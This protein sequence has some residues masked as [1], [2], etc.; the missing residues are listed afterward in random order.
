[1]SYV[2]RRG[3]R[4]T[5]VASKSS[6]SHIINDK[7]VDEYL[8]QCQFPK[9]ED[10]VDQLDQKLIDFTPL[11]SSQIKNVIAFDGGYSDVIVRKEFPSSKISF[12]QFGALVFTI[13]DLERL[14]N[15]PF[16]APEDM[17]K[18]K[19][20]ERQKLVV[21]VKN[22]SFSSEKTLTHSIRR[23]INDF[24]CDENVGLSEALKWIIFEEYNDPIES[25]TLAS[26]PHCEGTKISLRR[27][28]MKNDFTFSCS[29][30]TGTL[31]LIDVL[32]LH[33]AI[34]DELGAGGILGY[35]SSAL[36]QILVVYILK[37]LLRIAPD[38]ICETL[39]IKNGPLAFFGQTAN[40][41]KP[42]RKLCAWLEDKHDLALVGLEKSGPFVEHADE[43]S[44]KMKNGQVLLLDNEYIYKYITPGKADP[45]KPYGS[46]SYYSSK[47]IYKTDYG[48]MYVISLPTKSCLLQVSKGDFHRFDEVLTNV[49]K[50][51]C[52]MYDSSLIPVALANKL[53]SLSNHPSTQI[54]HKFAV[55]KVGR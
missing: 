5:V 7:V 29:E 6:H 31:Y 35:L 33:E 50:L 55:S 15:K 27:S 36:E 52:D 42:M 2:S 47:V 48:S 26:C 54:L 16:I 45:D 23:T 43:I 28:E 21:P 25:W 37:S 17:A 34:D 12:F 38:T 49:Q 14:E 51:K 46:T 8:D 13:E 24:M 39:L 1:M 44:G 32:R 3:N 22:I 41:H 40:L 4:P 10:E 19:D 53:V 20:L 30:C 18:L 11:K 9:T